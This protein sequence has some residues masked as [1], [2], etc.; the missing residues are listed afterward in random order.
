MNVMW[1]QTR[2][3]GFDAKQTNDKLIRNHVLVAYKLASDKQFQE[4]HNTYFK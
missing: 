4:K 3:A 2:T 1:G